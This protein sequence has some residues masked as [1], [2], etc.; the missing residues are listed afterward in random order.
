MHTPQF[1]VYF[2]LDEVSDMTDDEFIQATVE[3]R[4]EAVRFFS[5]ASKPER[6]LWVAKE[7]LENLDVDFSDDELIVPEND[8][9]DVT[10]RNVLF[11]IKE[12]L[13][14][15]RRRHAEF[16]DSLRKAKAATSIDELFEQHPPRDITYTEIYALVMEQAS[17]LAASKYPLAVRE[18]LDLLFYVNL[19]DVYG[20]VASPLPAS[21]AIRALGWRSVSFLAGY[22]SCVIVAQP[23]APDCLVKVEHQIK[24]RQIG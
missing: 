22:I 10:F 14:P 23:N 17:E 2:A 15:G 18:E 11:E 8:P 6:E 4:E 21:D 20:Y 1:G 12:I 13:D 9:P 3:A 7:F 24:R 16:K 5:S 19:E